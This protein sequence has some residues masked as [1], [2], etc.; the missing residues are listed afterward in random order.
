MYEKN[1]YTKPA[2]DNARQQKSNKSKLRRSKAKQTQTENR[3]Q[4]NPFNKL[5]KQEEIIQQTINNL[6]AAN[7]LQQLQ[8]KCNEKRH[9]TIQFTQKQQIINNIQHELILYDI[10]T[11]QRQF[12]MLPSNWPTTTKALVS[13]LIISLLIAPC[14]TT[15]QIIS[16]TAHFLK[17]AD[18]VNTTTTYNIY[19]LHQLNNQSGWLTWKAIVARKDLKYSFTKNNPITYNINSQFLI[20]KADINYKKV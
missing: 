2:K 3:I 12:K 20:I 13:A 6:I 16:N 9:I 7:H 19:Q 11:I 17:M 8:Q 15:I 5:S 18:I 1:Q 10:P 14:E 4:S